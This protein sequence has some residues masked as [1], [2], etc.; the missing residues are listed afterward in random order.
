[1]HLQKLTGSRV[2]GIRIQ[3]T[4]SAYIPLPLKAT[5]SPTKR[6]QQQEQEFDHLPLN[7]ALQYKHE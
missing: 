7:S 1:M 5:P 4:R 6:G 3:N 2:S